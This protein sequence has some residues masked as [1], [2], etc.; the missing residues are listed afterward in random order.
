MKCYSYLKVAAVLAFAAL[1]FPMSAYAIGG[2]K[3]KIT[4]LNMTLVELSQK[5]TEG[6]VAKEI[7]L[8]ELWLSEAQAQLV[9]EEE[10]ATEILVRK[11][12]AQLE[13]IKAL[14]DLYNLESAA[15]TRDK[16][17][18]EMRLKTDEEKINLEQIL[19]KK[20]HCEEQ[21]EILTKETNPEQPK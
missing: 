17:A 3:E 7:K 10:R 18:T 11:A 4:E 19:M 2:H 9:K 21:L 20:K 6:K 16:E 5:D 13:L 8:A 12:E 14:M 15:V 1:W